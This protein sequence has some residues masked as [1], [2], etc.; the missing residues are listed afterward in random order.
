MRS[1]RLFVR[2]FVCLFVC[3][4]VCLFVRSFV[5]LLVNSL[6]RLFVLSFVSSFVLS[7]VRSFVCLSINNQKVSKKTDKCLFA[8]IFR[9]T[10]IFLVGGSSK[11]HSRKIFS[12]TSTTRRMPGGDTHPPF[13]RFRLAKCFGGLRVKNLDMSND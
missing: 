7:F 9:T 6:V 13:G 3:W 4:L 1:F 11:T 5:C 2:S 10:R 12:K 8:V